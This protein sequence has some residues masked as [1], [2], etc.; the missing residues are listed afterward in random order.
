VQTSNL[1]LGENQQLTLRVTNKKLIIP[2]GNGSLD[3]EA[4]WNK[5]LLCEELERPAGKNN[6]GVRI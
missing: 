2:H 6:R 4:A 1:G 5:M 3:Q